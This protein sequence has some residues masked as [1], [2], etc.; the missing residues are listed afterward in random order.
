MVKSHSCQIFIGTSGWYY[1]DWIG[2]FY[3]KKFKSYEDLAFYAKTFDTVENNSAFYHMPLKSTIQKWAK[4]T[5]NDFI[6]SIKLNQSITHYQALGINDKTKALLETYFESINGL[7][8]KLGTVLIQLPARFRYDLKRLEDFLEYYTKNYPARTSIEFRN[9]YWL[10]KETYAV[11][12]KYNVALTVAQS[13]RYPLDQTITADFGYFRF[14][15]PEKLFMSSYSDKELEYWAGFIKN[16]AKTMKII[17][18]YFNNTAS[19]FA[20]KNA[21]ALKKILGKTKGPTA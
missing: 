8:R 18:V 14:H 5:P 11:L 10:T 21:L 9:Q 17:Y 6:F 4:A 15:G 2:T 3:P 12:K 16:C 7:K 19:T 13:S 20:I 1:Q